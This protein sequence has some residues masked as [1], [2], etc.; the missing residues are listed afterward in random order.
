MMKS[1]RD[2]DRSAPRVTAVIPT[3][4]RPDLVCRAVRSVLSQ[5]VTDIECIVVIDG[6][7]SATVEALAHI[8]DT[9]L[10]VLALEEN[11]GGNEARNFGVRAG[12]GEWIALL[13]DDDEW[14][15]RRLEIQLAV[16]TTPAPVTMVA[17]RFLDRMS[18]GD[19]VRPRKF[20]K[21]KQHISEFLWCEVSPL[22]GIEGFPQ[23]ST[24]LIERN[25][26]LEVPFTKNL[27]AL[28]DLDW[29]LHAFANPRMQVR[30]IDE[31]LIIFHN[32]MGR[33]R[34]AKRIDWQFCRDWAMRNRD[35]FTK[36]AFAFFLVIYC[37]N[38]AAQDGASWSDL[39][40]LLADC[41]RYG[42]ITPK[43]LW[44][45]SLYTLA[46]PMVAKCLSVERRKTLLYKV[47][48]FASGRWL[49]PEINPDASAKKSPSA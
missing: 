41:R 32:D 34:V 3:R 46:Y 43:L 42:K 16:A 33:A 37:V 26:L 4:N 24:W 35:L 19:L 15:P 38:P 1:E 11:V 47:T 44:L 30:F 12:R 6:P 21:P 29:L 49:L 27:K 23:T 13:D 36:R 5:T 20:P 25:F 18:Y 39:R 9:R 14:L 22:G 2:M 10:Q 48:S 31:P 45:Y 8:D 28:Q 40:S 7:D 17:S